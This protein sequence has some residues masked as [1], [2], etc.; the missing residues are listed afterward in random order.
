MGAGLVRIVTQQG[1]NSA[2]AP[3]SPL[4]KK[5]A[6]AC[7]RL[8]RLCI[9]QDGAQ[10]HGQCGTTD[11]FAH[12]RVYGPAPGFYR[13]DIGCRSRFAAAR[14]TAFLQ[15]NQIGRRSAQGVQ[16]QPVRNGF[17]FLR[18]KV[19]P[20]GGGTACCV[21]G[22]WLDCT[23]QGDPGFKRS[24]AKVAHIHFDQH[25]ARALQLLQKIA[26]GVDDYRPFSSRVR[27][28]AN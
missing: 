14:E 7:R 5:L 27:L 23:L 21:S 20:Y 15:L 28:A 18:E 24:A 11:N 2:A 22:S 3:D 13:P 1:M 8:H 4:A 6:R 12:K 19:H 9:C 10:L 16:A 26:E 17:G 25:I